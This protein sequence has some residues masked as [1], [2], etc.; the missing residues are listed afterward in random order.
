MP[1]SLLAPRTETQVN[2][3]TTG[4]K[5]GADFSPQFFVVGAPKA[6]TTSRVAWMW[7]SPRLPLPITQVMQQ[8]RTWH[9]RARSFC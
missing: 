1:P 4:Y 6:G 9:G 3:Y 5:S 7:R 2:T 8:P